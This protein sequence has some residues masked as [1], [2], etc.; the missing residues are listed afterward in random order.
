M[1]QLSYSD[2]TRHLF[3]PL[4]KASNAATRRAANDM[5]T[6]GV[7]QTTLAALGDPVAVTIV[8]EAE[9][10]GVPDSFCNTYI[11]PVAS[12]VIHSLPLESHANPTG[13]KHLSGHLVRSGLVMMSTNA[14]VL[15]ARA[16]GWPLEKVTDES[17]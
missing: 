12:D 4:Q 7:F 2:V 10:V 1:F 5:T 17:L 8:P 11:S 14:V 3:N 15:E 13:R 16:A 6:V 9:V